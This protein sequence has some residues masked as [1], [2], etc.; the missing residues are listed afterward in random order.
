MHSVMVRH[1]GRNMKKAK[2]MVYS[3]PVTPQREA[4]Y[5][6]WYNEVHIPEVCMVNGIVGA[7]RYKLS[8]AQRDHPEPPRGHQYLTEYDIEAET[9]QDVL[10]EIVRTRHTRHLSDAQ[11]EDGVT[12]LMEL[13]EDKTDLG[14]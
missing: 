11:A 3:S 7:R 12:I 13:I 9:L 1:A 10:D 5:N 6:R 14:R 2:L 4:E 8:E